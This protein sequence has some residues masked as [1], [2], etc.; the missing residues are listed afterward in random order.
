MGDSD[1]LMDVES[2]QKDKVKLD[3]EK[4]DEEK[5][6]EPETPAKGIP[7]FWLTILIN[8]SGEISNFPHLF[9]LVCL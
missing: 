3:G 4:K 1:K 6:D 7:E 9:Q 5:K 8:K 2:G